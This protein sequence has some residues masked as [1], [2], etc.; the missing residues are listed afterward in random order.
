[1][2]KVIDFPSHSV[3][4]W[5]N[6]SRVFRDNMIKWGMSENDASEFLTYFKPIFDKFSK[7]IA[8]PIIERRD[9]Y[10]CFID[11]TLN[12]AIDEIQKHTADLL[13]DRFYRELELFLI[14]KNSF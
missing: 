10:L 9:D 4:S 13:I 2:D 3:R 6:T 14:N 5:A 1:M 8:M 11:D 7:P 12:K